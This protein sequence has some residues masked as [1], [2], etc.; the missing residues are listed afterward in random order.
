MEFEAF[1]EAE[2]ELAEQL[3]LLGCWFGDAAQTDFAPVG[4]RPYNVGAVED[5]RESEGPHRRPLLSG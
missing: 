1:G 4:G 5:R 3:F 2:A